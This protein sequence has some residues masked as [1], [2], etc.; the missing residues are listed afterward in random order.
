M[1][2]FTEETAT[3][4][5]IERLSGCPDA[6]LRQ[7]MES[8]V[9][10]LHALVRETQ[11]TEDEWA[12]AIR[13]LTS[14]GHTCDE[15]RQEFI[16]LSDVLG[17]SMLVDAINHRLPEDFTQSTVLGPFHV[18]GAPERHSGDDISGGVAG[19]PL[20]VRGRVLDGEGEHI[21]G[22]ELDV[23]QADAEGFYDVQRPEVGMRL[24]G[25]LRADAEGSFRFRTIK[26]CSYPLP[27]D[28][29]V[30]ELLRATGRHPYRP[31]HIHFIV[32]APGFRAV[33]T[34]LFVAGDPHLGSDAV[35]GVKGSL[36]VPLARRDDAAEAARERMTAPFWLLERDFRLARAG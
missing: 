3:A 17:V 14:V 7:V 23:W 19:E 33:T 22:A 8:V 29:P 9:R 30:G 36:V 31:A 1:N 2:D 21:P 27:T 15:R 6:R 20:L 24:R 18:A 5:V 10:H 16:L 26:P 34:H 4:I 35:F 25:R 13:F 28:G 11:L 32:G 12:A